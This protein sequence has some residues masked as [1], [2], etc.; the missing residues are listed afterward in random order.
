MKRTAIS[1]L[2]AAAAACAAPAG[3]ADRVQIDGAGHNI[4]REQFG[5][6]VAAV[7]TF[8]AAHV[9]TTQQAGA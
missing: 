3:A 8:L 7:R 9:P 5:P 2:L 6:F 1:L 4:R